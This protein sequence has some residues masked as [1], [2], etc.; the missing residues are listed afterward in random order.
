M[1]PQQK[2]TE[3]LVKAIREQ[4]VDEWKQKHADRK[5]DSGKFCWGRKQ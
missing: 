5:D 2:A 3:E 4:K 1:F